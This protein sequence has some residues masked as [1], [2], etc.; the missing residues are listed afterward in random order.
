MDK[1][2]PIV[3]KTLQELLPPSVFSEMVC[4]TFYDEHPRDKRTID[5]TVCSNRGVV[6]EFYKRELM[7]SILIENVAKVEEIEL[8]RNTKCDIF[9]LVASKHEIIILSK[10]EKLEVHKRIT[11]V[12]TYS[13]NDL[14]CIGQAS[15]KVVV[16][17]DALPIV[18][19]ENFTMSRDR[20][21]STTKVISDE[22]LEVVRDLMTRLTEVEYSIHSNETI[23]KKYLIIRQETAFNMYQ[24]TEIDSDETVVKL[25]PNKISDFLQVSIKPLKVKCCNK[26]III[27][28][29]LHNRNEVPISEITVLLHH[30]N[31]KSLDYTT[32]IFNGLSMSPY[33]EEVNSEIG[34]DT[35]STITAVVDLKEIGNSTIKSINFDV[36]ISFK[37]GEKNYLLP[38]GTVEIST[39]D[40]TGE[41]FDILADEEADKCFLL[42]AVLCTSKRVN[43]KLRHIKEPD[44]NVT[45]LPDIFCTYLKMESLDIENVVI[46]K[47]SPHHILYGVMVVFEE[48]TDPLVMNFQVYS[49]SHWQVLALINYMYDVVPYKI[50]VT[51]PEYKLTGI[52]NDLI[53]YKDVSQVTETS[54]TCEIVKEC[55]LS[56][57][58]QARMVKEYLKKCMRI[59][60]E[61]EDVEIRSRAEIFIDLFA[62]SLT[63][64]VEFRNQILEESFNVIKLL[65]LNKKPVQGDSNLS[66]YDD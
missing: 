4:F 16:A 27:I 26:K 42:L 18:Y 3:L 8:L 12:Q 38:L 45:T 25:D 48:S 33:W 22:S 31:K 59:M 13:F 23:L 6:Q 64:Y 32:K 62:E 28:S 20:I 15:L 60:S 63:K 43:L 53:N 10:R 11:D 46:H 9:Y 55:S 40:F 17:D 66:T 49:R 1:Y 41:S 37:R 50:I 7:D 2:S 5:L 39:L 65:T 56:L 36:V 57:L 19:N 47:K 61:S 58:K 51:T 44:E 35:I 14:E 52:T 54:L 30:T 24:R 34:V 21:L 29:S